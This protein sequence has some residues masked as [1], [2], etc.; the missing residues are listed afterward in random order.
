VDAQVDVQ[1]EDPANRQLDP[2]L[3]G[4]QRLPLENDGTG[5][6]TEDHVAVEIT[7]GVDFDA[8][9]QHTTATQPERQTQ[10]MGIE[11]A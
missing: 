3:N 11:T 2:C 5:Q 9:C 6:G 8:G 4:S 10:K 1:L 7:G